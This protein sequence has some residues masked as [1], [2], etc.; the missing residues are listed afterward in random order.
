MSNRQAN[1]KKLI[2]LLQTLVDSYPDLRFSQ[3]LCNF[4]FVKHEIDSKGNSSWRD[5]YYVEPEAVGERVDKAVQ[6]ILKI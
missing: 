5:E 6:R 2:A 4:E 3:I 1:N